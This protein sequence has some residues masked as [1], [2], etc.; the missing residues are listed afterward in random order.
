MPLPIVSHHAYEVDIGPHVFPMA[1]YR[2]VRERL[3]AECTIAARDVHEPDP[4][5][6]DDVLLVHT[7]AYLQKLRE[8]RLSYQEELTLEVPF[9]PPLRDAM[10][11]M[12]GGTA[13][14]A[15]LALE[16]GIAVHLGGG[17]HHAFP[18]HGEGFCLVNDV[19]I[20]IR[21]LQRDRAI[22]RALVVDLDVHHGN[23]TA[24]VFRDDP[25]VFTFSM[26]QQHN[27]PAWKPASDL[28]IGL[29][30]HTGDE[31]YLD[32]LGHHLPE[33]VGR[34]RP[35]LVFY[36]AGADP[37]E[38]DQLGGLA[39]TRDGLR[40]RDAFVL[41]AMRAAAVPVAAV[42]AGGYAVLQ[43]DTVEIHCNTVRAAAAVR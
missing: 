13:L 29:A 40:K 36:L 7:P 19:A 18:D 41:N 16:R 39:L 21:M 12:T 10:W 25:T 37:Y 4:V 24:A 26:H 3:L 23:G 17:F 11:L 34:H 35:D 38:H 6:D 15:R 1:K 20:A 5:T 2:L 43:D 27:Y 14:A 42:L 28:D 33:I 32:A 22:E 31:P 8:E 9:S 30:D